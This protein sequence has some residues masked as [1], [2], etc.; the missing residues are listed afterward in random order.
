MLPRE[1]HRNQQIFIKAQGSR[2]KALCQAKKQ[3]EHL[4]NNWIEHP[5][6]QSEARENQPASKMLGYS[7]KVTTR[8][9]LQKN[10]YNQQLHT[11]SKHPCFIFA[12]ILA[13][14]K[15]GKSGIFQGF[16]AISLPVKGTILFVSPENN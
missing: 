6:T 8:K 4:G 9:L 3:Q 13:V 11:T 15:Q 7:L 10:H 16:T 12:P 5:W 1:S 2:L 14:Q